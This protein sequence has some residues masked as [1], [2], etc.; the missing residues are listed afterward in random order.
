VNFVKIDH[1]GSP[2]SPRRTAHGQMQPI[3]S[4]DRWR[5]QNSGRAAI[6]GD[7]RY[8]SLILASSISPHDCA[9]T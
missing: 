4:F 6:I 2:E 9:F 7:C 5:Y 3:F 1:G 8:G